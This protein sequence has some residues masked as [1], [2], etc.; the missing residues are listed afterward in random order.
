MLNYTVEDRQNNQATFERT[1]I[2]TNAPTIEAKD[3]TIQQ[4]ANFNS[5]ENVTA[6]DKEDGDLTKQVIVKQSDVNPQAPG[7]YH[8]TYAVKNADGNYVEKTIQVTV[9]APV[10]KEE[11]FITETPTVTAEPV[12]PEVPQPVKAPAQTLPKT[13]DQGDWPQDLA[14]MLFVLAGLEILS[15]RKK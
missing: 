2:V 5:L 7:I 6:S 1:V 3:Q 8:V 13:G 14:G 9:Q 15:M 12:A 4:G 10:P 11:L